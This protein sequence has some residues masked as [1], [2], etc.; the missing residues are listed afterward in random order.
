[1]STEKAKTKKKKSLV[2]PILAVLLLL[3]VGAVA[4]IP[5]ILSM[6]FARHILVDKVN[7]VG[8]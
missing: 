6:D 2:L 7:A 5:T 3:Q 8:K 1:M 4:L